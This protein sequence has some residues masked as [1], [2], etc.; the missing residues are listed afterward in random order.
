MKVKNLFESRMEPNAKM[1]M[2]QKRLTEIKKELANADANKK[3]VLEKEQGN[4]M[5]QI[6]KLRKEEK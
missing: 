2:L 4:V 3:K 6:S 1:D 5:D